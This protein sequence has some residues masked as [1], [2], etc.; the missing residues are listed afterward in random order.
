MSW[1]IF[2]V[3]FTKASLVTL[4]N[5]VTRALWGNYQYDPIITQNL[6]PLKNKKSPKNVFL[7]II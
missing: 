4:I 6:T 1:D 5:G 3:I 2:R 7:E